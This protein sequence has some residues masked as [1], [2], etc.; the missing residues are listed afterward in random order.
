MCETKGIPLHPREGFHTKT[1]FIRHATSL[2]WT[3]ALR[4]PLDRG[5]P[6]QISLAS[7]LPQL[8]LQAACPVWVTGAQHSHAQLHAVYYRT[9]VMLTVERQAKEKQSRSGCNNTQCSWTSVSEISCIQCLRCAQNNV[10][11]LMPKVSSNV[12]PAYM[13]R[14]LKTIYLGLAMPLFA[15]V[16]HQGASTSWSVWITSNGTRYLGPVQHE[17]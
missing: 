6:L 8:P 11:C 15:M 17:V 10:P 5:V 12:H 2:P 16:L 14:T 1:P 13:Y 9:K 3:T 7:L 4:R